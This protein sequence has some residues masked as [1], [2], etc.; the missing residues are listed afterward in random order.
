MI[1]RSWFLCTAWRTFPLRITIQGYVVLPHFEF[2]LMG[3]LVY[4]RCI[5]PINCS[6][7][8]LDIISCCLFSV[9]KKIISCLQSWPFFRKIVM[10]SSIPVTYFLSLFFEIFVVHV[11]L[12]FIFLFSGFWNQYL[13]TFVNSYNF[14]HVLSLKMV[15]RTCKKSKHGCGCVKPLWNFTVCMIQAYSLHQLGPFAISIMCTYFLL[16]KW[17][18]A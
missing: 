7:S 18:L 4:H 13:F 6:C 2:S 12:G 16:L 10:N 11:R 17:A 14:S 9:A 15:Q 8:P 3:S 5:F 1:S